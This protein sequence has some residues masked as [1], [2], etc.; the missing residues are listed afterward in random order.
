MSVGGFTP[1][2]SA[3]SEDGARPCSRSSSAVWG[4]EAMC[5][6]RG[7]VIPSTR[8]SKRVEVFQMPAEQLPLEKWGRRCQG[9]LGLWD[10]FRA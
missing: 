1:Q 3:Q 6:E 9:L 4:R 10:H 7:Y 2:N 5:A 8:C